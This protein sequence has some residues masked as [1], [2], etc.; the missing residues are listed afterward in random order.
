[1]KKTILVI[2]YS[3]EIHPLRDTI[4][5]HLY[6]WKHYSRH[7]IVYLNAAFGIPQ[8]LVIKLNPDVII[9]HTIFL[10][11]RWMREFFNKLFKKCEFISEMQCLKIAIPQDEFIN[12]DILNNFINAIGVHHVLTCANK[13]DWKKIY[14][15]INFKKVTLQTVLTGYIDERT[16]DYV[17]KLQKKKIKRDI[18]IGYRA[19]KAQYW[20]G[21]HGMRKVRVAEVIKNKAIAKGLKVDI[22]FEDNDV[23]AGYKWFEYLLRC[24]TTIGVE[25]GASILDSDGKIRDRVNNYLAKNPGSTFEQ[26]RNNCFLNDD[27]KLGL[28]CIAPRHLEACITKT[29][30]LLIEGKYN[31]ILKPWKHYIPIKKDYS[32]INKVLNTLQNEK[33][34][35]KITDNCYRDIIISEKFTYKKFIKDLE[36]KVIDSNENRDKSRNDDYKKILS[37]Y[38]LF[39][40]EK[41]D[42]LL[43]NFEHRLKRLKNS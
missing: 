29:C 42:W 31:G 11:Q 12:T 33:L 5:K 43:I 30:Q 34:V 8:R 39:F 20:L 25:A 19:W 22:S 16:V 28:A 6:S 21:E 27:N 37:F 9:F 32:N 1:M 3:R 18:D 7:K 14:N 35:K 24:K 2:Y 41:I 23:I 10:A 36:N 38:I 15:K 13:K 17:K 26:T 40:K 4:E